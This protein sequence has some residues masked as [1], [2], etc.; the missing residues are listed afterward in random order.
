[1][2]KDKSRILDQF[3]TKNEIAAL[4]YNVVLD[5]IE[6]NNVQFDFWLEPSAGT[7]SFFNLLP[8][9]KIG[10]DIDPKHEKVKKMDFLN[11]TF[12]KNHKYITIGNPPFGKNSSLAI[13]FFNKSSEY[14]EII[15]FIL[16]KTFKKNSVHAKLNSFFE[17]VY[18]KDM[19]E[20]S[21]IMNEKE[22]D[23]PC[24]FQI[25]RKSL[26]VRAL[27]IPSETQDFIFTKYKDEADFAIQRVGANAGTV[28]FNIEE[29]ALTSH[30]LIKI[31]NED[32]TKVHS[33][34]NS[35]D[36]NNQKYNTAGNPSIGK[37]ELINSYNEQ[38]EKYLMTYKDIVFFREDENILLLIK[39]DTLLLKYKQKPSDMIFEDAFFRI[40]LSA[41]T[42]SCCPTDYKRI[43]SLLLSIKEN[44]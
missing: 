25:W 30:Y 16:P 7:G 15:A 5:F 21:F 42:F 20:N 24:V 2:N 6:K 19:P 22:K 26:H 41:L 13:K 39:R 40:H 8:S 14:S 38:H 29:L 3:Y 12:K 43:K 17:L 32:K 28:K 23:V 1:M 36:W 31:V 44:H 9:N 33:I 37:E 27:T 18:E 10:L 35:I 4:C 34:L 11:Y